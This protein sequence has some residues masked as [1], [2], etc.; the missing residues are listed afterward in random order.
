MGMSRR[1]SEKKPRVTMVI[2]VMPIRVI[3]VSSGSSQVLA[4]GQQRPAG[5][6]WSITRP[7]ATAAA[8]ATTMLSLSGS[9]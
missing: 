7:M 8:M 4:L 5:A 3:Q 1:G 9:A 6:R 2:T